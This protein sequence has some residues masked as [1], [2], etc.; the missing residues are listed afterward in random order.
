MSGVLGV[1]CATIDCALAKH[2]TLIQNVNLE[3]LM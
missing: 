3:L 2:T 1:H